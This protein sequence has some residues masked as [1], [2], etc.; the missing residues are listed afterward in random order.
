MD[1]AKTCVM[2]Q[3]LRQNPAFQVRQ[4][5]PAPVKETAKGTLYLK[6]NVLKCKW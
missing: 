5:M 1:T 2:L 4:G 3:Y 6:G